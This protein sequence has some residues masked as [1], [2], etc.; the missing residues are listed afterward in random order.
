MFEVSP[1][2]AP[3]HMGSVG[4]WQS[5]LAVHFVVQAAKSWLRLEQ[6]KQVV[7]AAQG[8]PHSVAYVVQTPC[9]HATPGV[10]LNWIVDPSSVVGAPSA[11][12]QAGY[13]ASHFA[14][15]L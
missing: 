4:S 13:I 1:T 8:F 9:T 7:P 3:W 14:S 6:L 10:S 5:V 12:P 11:Q 15:R 2:V